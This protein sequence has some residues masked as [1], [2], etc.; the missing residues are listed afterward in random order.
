MSAPKAPA[1]S[2]K[3]RLAAGAALLGVGTILTTITLYV[4]LNEVAHR[5]EEAVA[6]ETRVARYA[7]LSTQATTFLVVATEAIQTRQ[8]AEV[9]AARLAPVTNQ[10]RLTFSQ[11]HDDVEHAVLAARNLG[12]DAQSRYGT[13]SLGLARMEA[14]LGSTLTGLADETNNAERLRAYIDTFAS[15]LDPLLSQAVNT[16]LLFRNTIVGGIGDLRLKLTR[17]SFAIALGTLVAVGAFYFGLIRPQFKR[18]DRLR[19]VASQIG[20]GNFDVSLPVVRLDEIGQ[21]SAETNRMAAALLAQRKDVQTEWERLNDTIAERTEALRSANDALAEI[22]DKRRRFF[23]D[24]SHE[25]RTPLTVIL[26]EAQIGKKGSPEPAAA[27]AT[28]EARAARLNRRIDDLLRLARSDTGQLA[29]DLERVPLSDITKDL[30][31]EIQAEIDNAGMTLTIDEMPDDAV[32]CDRNWVH[33]VLVSLMRNSIRHARQGGLLHVSAELG[34]TYAGLN[35]TDNGGGIAPQDQA[36]VFDR[37]SQG[38]SATA[39]EGFG[40]G[41]ALAHWVITEQGGRIDLTSP[42]PADEA[43]GGAPGTKISVC[44]PRPDA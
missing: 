30:A 13:Q 11:L 39:N 40:V 9:R 8:T 28:I 7:N 35:V 12:L 29:L 17:I 19:S 22:D 26:M 2:L 32:C 14:L 38:S 18:L 37:F 27:F 23:A 36:H 5:L 20:Q 34:E 1:L 21:L 24:I 42:L 4:G 33:Q 43:L 41:L 25:L 10:L 44:L 3:V 16:E 6:S 31:A 15:G